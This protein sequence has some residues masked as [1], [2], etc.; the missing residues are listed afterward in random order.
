MFHFPVSL[1]NF[2]G[3]KNGSKNTLNWTIASE[4]NNL[5]FDVQRSTD[6]AN[7]TFP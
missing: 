3:Y 7:Y 1:S 2:S 5:G 4:A 6:G